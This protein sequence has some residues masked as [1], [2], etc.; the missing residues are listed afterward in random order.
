MFLLDTVSV[1]NRFQPRPDAGVT[2]WLEQ[3]QDEELF[4]SAVTVGEIHKG[5]AKAPGTARSREIRRWLDADFIPAMADRILPVTLAV[6]ERW[7]D[8]CGAALAAGRPVPSVDALIAATAIVHN[9][10]VVTRNVRHFELCGAR[11]LNPWSG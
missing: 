1:S 6:A 2:R 10:T 3:T 8:I 7:G 5:L 11:V 9:L 4:A